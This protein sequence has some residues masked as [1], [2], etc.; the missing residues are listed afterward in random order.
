MSL[1]DGLFVNRALLSTRGVDPRVFRPMLL[2]HSFSMPLGASLKSVYH[3]QD[4][5]SLPRVAPKN[6]G[7]EK[8]PSAN[9]FN[10]RE[11][12]T[13]IRPQAGSVHYRDPA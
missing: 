3:C 6:Q 5:R 8:G 2:S 13:T 10:Y 12:G 4:E 11:S 9:V 1:N 7:F